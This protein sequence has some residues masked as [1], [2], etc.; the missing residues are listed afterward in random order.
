G[1]RRWKTLDSNLARGKSNAIQAL[2]KGDYQHKA[3]EHYGFLPNGL[4]A[5]LLAT[6]KGV[7]QDTAP[8]NVVGGDKTSTSND[9]QI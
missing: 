9:P 8:A 1:G 6:D 3:E 2:R 5:F 4:F 7:R